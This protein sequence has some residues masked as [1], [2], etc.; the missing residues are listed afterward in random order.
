[1]G[2]SQSTGFIK[3]TQ[4]EVQNK[5][6]SLVQVKAPVKVWKKGQSHLLCHF[7]SYDNFDGLE[8]SLQNPTIDTGWKN[9]NILFS[10]V[11]RGLEYFSKGKVTELNDKAG[12]TVKVGLYI[13]RAEKR[14]KERLLTF[15]HHQAYAYFRVSHVKDKT[16]VL[17]FNQHREK[18]AKAFERFD[19]IARKKVFPDNEDLNELMG[20]RVL[21]ISEDGV[22]F[23]VNK[24]EGHFFDE[25]SQKG[26][27]EFTL[28]VNGDVFELNEG[29]VIYNISYVSSTSDFGPMYKVGIHF[30]PEE[31][32]R[33]FLER[34][35]ASSGETSVTQKDFEAFV[36][37][38]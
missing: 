18:N 12:L 15:P 9:K 29:E 17:A 23:L 31:K 33:E 35:L 4:K 1:M 28:L 26:K 6:D 38:E 11:H 34:M 19:E 14:T 16:N 25:E 10:F 30:K 37:E 22:S 32:L 2:E 36:E 13:F 27:I 20:F 8:L 5:I 24:K 7:E 3:L 21:D